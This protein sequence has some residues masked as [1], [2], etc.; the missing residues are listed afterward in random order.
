MAGFFDGLDL[1]PPGLV[2]CPYWRPDPADGTLLR[3]VD[4]FGAV[5]RK[6]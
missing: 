6:P 1:V 3:E 4:E 5:G 2:S